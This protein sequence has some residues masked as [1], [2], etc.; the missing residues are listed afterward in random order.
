MPA[1]RVGPFSDARNRTFLEFLRADRLASD[2]PPEGL[3][4]EELLRRGLLHRAPG[5]RGADVAAEQAWVRAWGYGRPGATRHV[6]PF[7]SNV[8]G[9][10]SWTRAT[11]ESRFNRVA[12]TKTAGVLIPVD[13]LWAAATFGLLAIDL[14]TTTGMRMNEAMQIRLTEDAFVR[15]V[16]PAP[17]ARAILRLASATPSVSSRKA[18]AP[19]PRTPSSS[20]ERPCAC[21]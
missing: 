13:S 16:M 12:Q 9:L 1:R 4:F 5:V 15:L 8:P 10:L 19:T 3:W 14:F 2:A 20:D 6:A 18:S 11:G 17:P 21:S 7:F